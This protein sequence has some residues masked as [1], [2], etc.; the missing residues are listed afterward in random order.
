MDITT[1]KVNDDMKGS[2]IIDGFSGGRTIGKYSEKRQGYCITFRDAD[3]NWIIKGDIED[4][5]T[6]YWSDGTVW[7]EI[8]KKGLSAKHY[9]GAAVAG[10]AT[11]SAVG[12]LLDKKFFKKGKCIIIATIR[13]VDGIALLHFGC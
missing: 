12:Y 1:L 8:I 2:L 6:I 9:A 13:R 7:T 3:E 11:G 4:E 10:A 5:N